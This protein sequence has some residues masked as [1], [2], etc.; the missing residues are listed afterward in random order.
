MLLQHNLIHFLIPQQENDEK[1]IPISYQYHTTLNEPNQNTMTLSPTTADEIKSII[2]ELKTNKTTGTNSIPTKILKNKKNELAKP[3]CDLINLVFQIS[4]LP[5]II[6][7]A[8]IIPIYRKGD[9]LECDKHCPILL[10]S[11]IGKL[12][13]NSSMLGL[14]QFRFRKRHST[15]HAL[16]TITDKV[17]HTMD[18]NHYMYGV[19]LDFQKAFDIVNYDILLS[20]LHCY[21]LRDTP[22]E[23]I[24]SYLTNRKQYTYIN[25]SD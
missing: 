2:K 24:K 25:D 12:I 7:T 18:N 15:N 13:E 21:G 3:L 6:Q 16:I 23:L 11:N 4:I 9:P 8:K 19:F 14:S 17:R 5:G 10:L 20:K 1:L 22:F